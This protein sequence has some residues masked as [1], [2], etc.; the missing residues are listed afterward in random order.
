MV[1]SIVLFNMKI[2]FFSFKVFNN[3]LGNEGNI[4]LHAFIPTLTLTS[5]F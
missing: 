4:V 3:T 1:E 2:E 5:S